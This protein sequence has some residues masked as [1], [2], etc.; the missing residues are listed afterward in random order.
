M[1][2]NANFA[3]AKHNK[4]CS[5][6][7]VQ[8]IIAIISIIVIAI[9]L[10]IIIIIIVIIVIRVIRV[11]IIVSILIILITNKVIDSA[12][13]QPLELSSR[14]LGTQDK[15]PGESQLLAPTSWPLA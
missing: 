15:L 6:I 14:I 11:K 2:T 7:V 8:I 13:R 3:T 4:S 9:I 5:P 1:L 10:A 12:A